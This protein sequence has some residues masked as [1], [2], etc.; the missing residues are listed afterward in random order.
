M[1]TDI[2]FCMLQYLTD[3]TLP[4]NVNEQ[5]RKALIR[6]S[7]YFLV[8]EEQLFKRNKKEPT[9]P[10]KVVR[11]NE[12]DIILYNVHSDPLAGHFGLEETFRRVAI[13]YYWPQYYDDIRNY[14]KSCDECQRRGRAKRNEP[15]HPIKVGQPFDRIGMDIVG[16]LP[17]TKKGNLYIVVA[18]DY[19]TK[20]P[21]ARA[22]M[23]AKASS[24]VP[25]FYE[26][27]ICRHGC[28][29]VLLTDR[30]THF[31]N[32]MLNSLCDELGVK[33]KLSTAYH[34]QTN[35]LVE[36]FNRTLCEVLAK[37]A[38]E[39]KDD[40]DSYIPSAL[41]AYRTMRQGTTRHEPFYL[42]YGREAT[43]PIDFLIPTS[44][45]RAE[46]PNEPDDLLRRIYRIIG[47]LQDDRRKAQGNIQ[48]SQHKQKLRHDSKLRMTTFEIGALVLLY[49]SKLK[50]HGK[51]EEKWK[52]PYRICEVLGNGAYKLETIDRKVLKAP[53]NGD[54]LK[55][56]RERSTN[57]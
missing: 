38:N 35:G 27:I 52:G 36:R 4:D 11:K 7:R 30:G 40:W 13:R 33:H 56:Y 9:R 49:K 46:T 12:V 6:K 47:N 43:L 29:K 34:P 24:M 44:I 10:L 5:Q 57:D 25:F 28:P 14:V 23:N 16:P 22:L 48:R 31:V 50:G 2:Y 18:T 54:R 8:I 1:D 32:E 26:D 20:W 45:D 37:F 19:L 17:M 21:E 15:L 42:T 53:I 55:Q 51:L 3:H 39:Q 41:F